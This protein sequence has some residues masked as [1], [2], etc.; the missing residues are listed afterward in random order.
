MTGGAGN[1]TTDFSISFSW[2][3]ATNRTAICCLV[4]GGAGWI[5]PEPYKVIC[6]GPLAE[7]S[8][9]KPLHRFHEGGL[10]VW[11]PLVCPVLTAKHCR[12]WLTLSKEHQNSR[13]CYFHRWEEVHSELMWQTWRALWKP[14][15]MLWCLYHGSSWSV[16]RGISIEV[17]TDQYRIDDGTLVHV[18]GGG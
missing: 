2:A 6:S 12:A 13:I 16:W 8:L 5:L 18:P 4:Q 14:Q 15:W 17:C 11:L 10:R 9:T 3:T 7:I 1:Q